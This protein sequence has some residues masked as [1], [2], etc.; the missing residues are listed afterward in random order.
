MDVDGEQRPFCGGLGALCGVAVPK[1]QQDSRSRQAIAGPYSC[2][3]YLGFRS[4]CVASRGFTPGER[5]HPVLPRYSREAAQNWRAEAEAWQPLAN[6]LLSATAPLLSG[7]SIILP[8]REHARRG[9][10]LGFGANYGAP[11]DSWGTYTRPQAALRAPRQV[12]SQTRASARATHTL[13]RAPY[14]NPTCRRARSTPSSGGLPQR[15]GAPRSSGAAR[16]GRVARG[17]AVSNSAPHAIDATS[18]PQRR[19]GP[20][21]QGT[22]PHKK[23]RALPYARRPHLRRSSF[24]ESFI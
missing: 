23:N 19:W 5:F 20:E 16:R 17:T 21:P 18:Y 9:T 3:L 12:Q 7:Y 14:Q 24:A 13:V 6:Q 15:S 4:S 8:R 1:H 10:R 11:L 22:R 2:G